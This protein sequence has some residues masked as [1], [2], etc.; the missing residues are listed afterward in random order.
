MTMDLISCLA[1]LF[2]DYQKLFADALAIAEKS[3][4]SAMNQIDL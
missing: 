3:V 2:D 4:P 1:L